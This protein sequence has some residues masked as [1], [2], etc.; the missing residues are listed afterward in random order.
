MPELIK[1]ACVENFS[2]ALRA[3]QAGANRI[4]LCGS[5]EHDGLT[6]DLN[7]LKYCLNRLQIPTKVMIRH[8]AGNF[9]YDQ[10][11]EIRIFEDLESCKQIGATQF[12]FGA[13]L[14][15]GE[16]DV[17][18]IQKFA[19]RLGESSD[20]RITIHKAID[21]TNK[22]L[23]ELKRLMSISKV[24]S[25]LSSGQQQTALAGASLLK[26]MK[27]MCIGRLKLIAAGKITSENLAL[28]HR[29]LGFKEYHGRK[30]VRALDDC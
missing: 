24:D 22:P 30:I 17:D 26:Q 5:L 10:H 9:V 4:E 27:R 8:R 1:E 7:E 15:S 14:E 3:Q 16:L 11:D 12:V 19:D 18:L 23:Q 25:I 21:S 20:S 6:P 28:V 29:V 2:Q 13:M